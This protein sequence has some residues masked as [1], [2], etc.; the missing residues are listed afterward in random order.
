M[1]TGGYGAFGEAMGRI[2]F[3]EDARSTRMNQLASALGL[4]VP[5][6]PAA[7]PTPSSSYAGLASYNPYD[8]WFNQYQQNQMGLAQT[9]PG[10]GGS[11]SNL[12]N[13]A[14]ILGGVGAV[15]GAYNDSRK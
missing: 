11:G 5:N 8:T 9:Y 13:V 4:N 7:N 1:A 6:A 14:S 15:W 3:L 2:G 10:Q 12:G